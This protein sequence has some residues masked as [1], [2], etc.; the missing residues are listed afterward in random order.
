MMK[1]KLTRLKIIA[2]CVSIFYAFI[3]LFVGLSLD[4]SYEVFK[5]DNPIALIARAMGF[6]EIMPT[7]Q[8]WIMLCFLLIWLVIYVVSV[9]YVNSYAKNKEESPFNSKYIL[10]YAIL[11]FICLLLSIGIATLFFL[12][13][14][15]GI[16]KD[17]LIFTFETLFFALVITLFICL[18]CFSLVGLY[19]NIKNYKKPLFS[20]ENAPKEEVRNHSLNDTFANKEDNK[21]VNVSA[22]PQIIQSSQGLNNIKDK[23]ELFKGLTKIDKEYFNRG[24]LNLDSTN[25]SLSD[26]CKNLQ[27]YLAKEEKLYYDLNTLRSFI[28]GLSSSSLIILEGISGTGKS[29]LPRYFAKFIGEEAYFEAVQATYRDRANLLGYYNEFTNTYM[30]TDF[31]KS[32]YKASIYPNKLNFVVLDE[33]NISRVE[34]YFADFLSVLEYP[35]DS[36][37]IRLMELPLD[38]KAP[39]NLKNGYLE[40][41]PNNY[42]IGTC[43]KDDSTYTLT[44]KVIDRAIVIDFKNYGEEIKF[45]E[46]V[47]PI[48][49]S[50]NT[51]N[52]LFKNA[53]DNKEYN[54]TDNDFKAILALLKEME[55]LF[56]VVIGNRILNQLKNFTPVYVSC[57]GTKDD[58]IDF[59]FSTKILRK[60]DGHF[61]SSLKQSLNKLKQYLKSDFIFNMNE[62]VKL[63]DRYIRRLQ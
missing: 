20:A 5:D 23:E 25:L 51:L 34:Y 2:I 27:I 21:N 13:N 60:L 58:A 16:Y 12:P 53:K 28:A 36:R 46:D 24:N 43:N 10:I 56:D 49:L 44:D 40:I 30:E 9:C 11:L 4:A 29:S 6:N 61:E 63:I 33:M 31:L 35:E 32:L 52:N 3:S 42:F 47:K 22:S 48:I 57:G 50:Y 55:T 7:S 39:N 18:L 19:I 8:T 15:F 54:L 26:I 17:S 1:L 14:N 59:M 37:K 62:S 38:Y 41:S 45:N